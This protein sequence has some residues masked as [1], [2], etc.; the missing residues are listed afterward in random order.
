MKRRFILALLFGWLTACSSTGDSQPQPPVESESPGPSVGEAPPPATGSGDKWSLWTE[1]TTLRG[2]NLWQR[3]VVPELD[4]TEFL[5]DG[6]I[7]PP[8]TQADFDGLADAGANYVNLSVPGIFTMLPPYALDERAQAHLDSLL[9]MAARADLF[10]VIS[11][12]TGPGRS[13]FTFYRDGAGDWFDP[14]LLIESVWT[15]RAAQDAWVEMWRD[16]AERYRDNPVVAGYDLMVEP[17][18]NE[19]VLDVYEPEEFYPDHA[20]ELYDW[21]Q[22]YPRLVAGI[23]EVDDQTPILVSAPGYG[24]VRWLSTLIPTDDPRTVYMVHQYAPQAAYTHQGLPAEN[25]YPSQLDVDGD[26]SPET[27]DRAWLEDYLGPI[28]DFRDRHNVPVAVN[29]Y[30]VERWAPGA[31][32][33]MADEIELFEQLGLNHSFWAWFP[34]WRPW[35]E[36]EN[37]MNYLFG[38]DP[39][40][41]APVDNELFGVLTD[42]WGRNSLWPSTFGTGE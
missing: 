39:E 1:G 21:N 28:A 4:G 22:L 11:F 37:S 27:F 25:A 3:I 35:S 30:G 14:E 18:S 32:D 41:T 9:E 10:A 19:I 24:S 23:R 26:G 34:E 5:G 2:A 38:P 8:W 17:N 20:G 42:A 36:G 29:E 33:F 16:T 13:D 31:A 15:D 40:N 12:R 7:G 6:Y